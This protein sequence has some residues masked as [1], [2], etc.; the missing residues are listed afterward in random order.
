[1]KRFFLVYLQ[2]LF[3]IMAG[4]N[5]FRNPETYYRLIPPYLPAHIQLNTL[6][7]IAEIICGIFL[8][9]SPTRKWAAYSIV[10]MLLA[11]IPAHIYFIKMGSCLPDLCVPQWVGWTRL[12]ILHPLLIAWAWY[13]KNVNLKAESKK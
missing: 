6:V 12:L 1:M 11:F 2:S 8:F 10:L 4:I 5:H 7:G 13:A 9:F 3:Y